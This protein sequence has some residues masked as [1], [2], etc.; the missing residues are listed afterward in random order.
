MALYWL[1]DTFFIFEILMPIQYYSKNRKFSRSD[2]SLSFVVTR[3]HSLYHSLSFAVPLVITCCTSPCHSLSFVVTRCIFRCH[4]LSLVVT[5][6]IFRCHSLSLVVTRC[7]IRLSF[8]KR[9][10]FYDAGRRKLHQAW[11]F[12]LKKYSNC[13]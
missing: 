5:R 11:K 1:K 8:Y 9:S 4:L 12:T 3:C 13:Y 7:I 2:C 6:C 10:F